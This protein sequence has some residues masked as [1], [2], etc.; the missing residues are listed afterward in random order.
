MLAAVGLVG[1]ALALPWFAQALLFGVSGLGFLMLH[2]SVQAEVAEL[3]PTAR[4]SSF[5]MHSFFFF[6]G[7]ALGPIVVGAMLHGA[8]RMTLMG[9][10]VVLGLTGIAVSRLFRR[11]RTASG[12]F[13]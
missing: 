6:L 11:Y 5:S 4:A 12:S 3:A 7:Q 10:A 8:G 2:N 9:N 1:V 13:G